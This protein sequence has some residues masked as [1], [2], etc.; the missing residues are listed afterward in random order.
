[1]AQCTIAMAGAVQ[2]GAA[3]KYRLFQEKFECH[4]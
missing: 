4:T 2:A 1:M 3:L